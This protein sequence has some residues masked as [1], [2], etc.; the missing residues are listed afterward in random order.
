MID[1]TLVSLLIAWGGVTAIPVG[2]DFVAQADVVESD[3]TPMPEP[4]QVYKL[5]DWAICRDGIE[6]YTLDVQHPL[7][8]PLADPCIEHGGLRAY[9]PGG[10]IKD[11]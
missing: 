10:S 2:L 7:D 6:I 8:G 9:G 11:R 1:K 4:F 5:A 3:N